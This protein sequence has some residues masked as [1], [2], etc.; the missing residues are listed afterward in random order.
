[1]TSI[2]SLPTAELQKIR[3][4]IIKCAENKLNVYGL[5]ISHIHLIDKEIEAR[6]SKIPATDCQ[7]E[8]NERNPILDM[9]TSFI[10]NTAY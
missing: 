3:Q 2:K 10:P 6:T 7:D 1:M 9:G 8:L 5:D 4:D